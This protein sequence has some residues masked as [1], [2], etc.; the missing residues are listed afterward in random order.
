MAKPKQ[1]AAPAAAAAPAQPVPAEEAAGS[2]GGGSLMIDLSSVPDEQERPVVPRGIYDATVDDVT[3]GFSQS[4]GNPMWTW[5]FELAASA[6]EHA[7]RKMFFHTPFVEVMMPRVK[8]VVS[9]VAPEL[10]Q[11]PFDPEKIANDGVLV[12]KACRIRL[13]IKPYEGKPRNNVRDVLPAEE[14]AGGAFLAAGQ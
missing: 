11:G 10:L 13:D 5:V 2:E 6:G 4:S 3:Y 1:E 8:K 14:G 7:G 9:R 12:G